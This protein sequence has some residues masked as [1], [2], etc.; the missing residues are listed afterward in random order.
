MKYFPKIT[1]G[2]VYLSPVNANDYELFTKWMNDKRITD[3][4]TTWPQIISI[5]S[6]K[7]RLENVAKSWGYNLAI[8]R[9]DGDKLLWTVWLFHIDHINQSAELWISIGDFDEHSKW[10]GA[11]AINAMLSFSYDTLNLYNV[12]LQVK[13]FNKKAIACYKKVWFQEIWTRHHCQY[14]NGEWHDLV[15]MEMLKP[16]WQEKNK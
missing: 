4:I 8:I 10:Y 7:E 12:F 15:I 14:C 11:D 1:R 5:T 16:D 9:K 2:D 3:W 13:S 6:E